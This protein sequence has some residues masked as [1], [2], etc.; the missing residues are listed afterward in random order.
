MPKRFLT[1]DVLKE[2]SELA[3]TN[4]LEKLKV[5]SY[6]SGKHEGRVYADY[7]VGPRLLPNKTKDML[8]YLFVT[9]TER[10]GKD[11]PSYLTFYVDLK[12][13]GNI[14]YSVKEKTR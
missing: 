13:D 10:V 7:Q 4:Q 14:T 3:R 2:V 11:W 6:K 9:L 5:D 8:D 12:E 1:D